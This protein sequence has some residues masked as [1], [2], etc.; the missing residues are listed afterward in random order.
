MIV[1]QK[2]PVDC[3]TI[4]VKNLPY[5]YTEDQL[6]NLFRFCGEIENVRIAYNYQTKVSKGFGYVDFKEQSAL[7]KALSMDGKKIGNR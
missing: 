7:V 5:E 4:F 1:K 2:P 3:K 6:G